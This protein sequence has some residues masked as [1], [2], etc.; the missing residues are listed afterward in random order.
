MATGNVH[1]K[2]DVSSDMWFLRY[3]A[4]RQTECSS[5]YST[6]LQTAERVKINAAV[7]CVL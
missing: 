1:R 5:Q 3:G 4:D 2:S 7:G 6:L